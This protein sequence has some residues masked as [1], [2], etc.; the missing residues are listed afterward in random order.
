VRLMPIVQQIDFFKKE[1]QIE[2]QDLL[3]VCLELKHQFV[4]KGDFVFQFGDPGHNF[5][6]ALKGA[7][8]V[9]APDPAKKD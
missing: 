9:R 1:I 4:E 2:G 6:I 3:E 5:Y 7:L 8:S